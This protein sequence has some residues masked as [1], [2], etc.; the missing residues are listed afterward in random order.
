MKAHLDRAILLY[1]QGRHELAAQELRQVIAQDPHHPYP[2]ALLSLVLTDHKQLE[3]A[4][5]EARQAIHLA[6]DFPLAHYAHAR[7]L[8]ERNRESEALEAI[9]EAIRLDPV[10]PDY[11]AVEAAILFD[12][13]R[14]P[15][16]LTAAER[17]LQLDA[18]HVGCANLR[19]MALVKLGRRDEAGESIATALAKDPDNAITHANQGWTRLHAG[20]ARQALE[21]FREALRLDPDNEWARAG[22]VE[23]LKA[24]NV[25]YAAMLKY[26][27]WMSRLSPGAQWGIILGGLFLS[28]MLAGAAHT[29]PGLAPVVLPL[30]ILYVAFALMTWLAYPLFN[31][32]LRLNR[33]GRLALSREQIVE[34][35]WIG[36][37]LALALVSLG[38]CLLEGFAGPW[39]FP[40]AVF[41]LLLMPL[42]GTF[43]CAT[44]W[45]RKT[46]VGVTLGLLGL[47]LLAIGLAWQAGSAAGA[48][49]EAMVERA[50]GALGLFGFGILGSAF[51]ANY[52]GSV[53]PR[54]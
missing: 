27:L 32:M 43:R 28:R 51:L 17:G 50:V 9:R 13:R 29:M 34:S 52:L 2:H 45:P 24:R 22:I 3:E 26:F 46:M 14:W 19:A 37:S 48:E 5:R 18:E 41:G 44:G 4:T 47:G 23:A 35:N 53:R 11:C 25:I 20:D 16:A 12:L 42:S 30:R 49:S 36:A 21:H 54:L 40:L 7:V 38:G 1:Q 33:F 10:D 39:V 31:L 6:P 8:N 15:E